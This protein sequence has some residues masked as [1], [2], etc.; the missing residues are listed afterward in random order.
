MSD[1]R[2]PAAV[3]MADTKTT[4]FFARPSSKSTGT[5]MGEE[6][7]SRRLMRT[8]RGGGVDHRKEKKE[9]LMK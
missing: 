9:I 2:V 5:R 4:H 1:A 6:L 3:P 7:R 8:R